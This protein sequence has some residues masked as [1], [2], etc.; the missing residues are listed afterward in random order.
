MKGPLG[1]AR[2]AAITL[3]SLGL[4]FLLRT[5]V[6][7]GGEAGGEWKA[8]WAKTV[9]A[10]RKEA[11]L[12]IYISGYPDVLKEFQKEYPDIKVSVFTGR[13]SQL[14]QRLVSERRAQKYLADVYTGGSTTTYSVL[15]RTRSLDPLRPVLILPEVIDESHWF[16]GKHRYVDPEG[17]Y[18]FVYVGSVVTG[19]ASFNTRL[20]NPNDFK[21]YWDFLDPKW[22]GKMVM[23]DPREAG[24]GSGYLRWIY[25]NPELGPGF[26]K[27]LF[28][29]MD[30]TLTRD[31]RQGVDWLAKGKFAICFFCSG[32]EEAQRQGLTVREFGVHPWKEGAGLG[33]SLGTL[34]LMNRAPHPNAAKLF[35]NWYLTRRGQIFLQKYYSDDDGPDSLRVDIPKDDVPPDRRRVKGGKYLDTSKAEWIEM[36]PILNVINDALAAAGRK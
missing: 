11:Q 8:E 22:K 19:G 14:G 15:H 7:S 25:Y 31:Y 6:A 17:L 26:I 27:R 2:I 29:E 33:N 21:S 18:I 5:A 4:E 35:V 28:G 3:G 24:P 20:V 23:R 10:A 30:L 13:G 34:A 36:K 1:I 32:I 9:A 12:V 16:E